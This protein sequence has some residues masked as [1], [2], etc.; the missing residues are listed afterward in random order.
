MN[1]CFVFC[2]FV[3]ILAESGSDALSS[4]ALAKRV[5]PGLN[6]RAQGA[7][8]R[9]IVPLRPTQLSESTLHADHDLIPRSAGSFSPAREGREGWEG[10]LEGRPGRRARAHARAHA[11][12]HARKCGVGELR[13]KGGY[14]ALAVAGG[15]ILIA[16]D[17]WNYRHA[18]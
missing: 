2:L 7:R 14:R 16:L 11:R 10:G 5:K 17:H 12:T 8:P 13:T 9:R 4:K 6:L 3:K 15:T 1:Y 18:T